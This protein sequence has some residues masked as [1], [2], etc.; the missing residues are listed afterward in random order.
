MAV[1]VDLKKHTEIEA[2]QTSSSLS[3][4]L[5]AETKQ[6]FLSKCA[7]SDFLVTLKLI[8]FID[9]NEHSGDSP[10]RAR[11]QIKHKGTI[12]NSILY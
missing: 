2:G 9:L 1:S 12:D 11:Y 10:T 8:N 3:S 6:N 5:A 4:A 7:Y